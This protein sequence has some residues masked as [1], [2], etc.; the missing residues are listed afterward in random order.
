[1]KI[2]VNGAEHLTQAAHIGALLEE[3]RLAP[4]TVLV[5]RNAEALRREDFEASPLN[6]GDAIEILRVAAG[7]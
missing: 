7:G 3:L 5:E 2:R 4:Q 1:M 6:D